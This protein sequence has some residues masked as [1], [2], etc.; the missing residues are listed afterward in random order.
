MN[1]KRKKKLQANG[2]TPRPGL[3]P[4]QKEENASPKFKLDDD[5][6]ISD[7]MVTVFPGDIENQ[8]MIQLLMTPD[9]TFLIVFQACLA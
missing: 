5:V 9:D 1:K 7:R 4:N 6:Y 8:N 3:F 2:L